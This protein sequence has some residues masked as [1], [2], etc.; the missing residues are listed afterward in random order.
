MPKHY[1]FLNEHLLQHNSCIPTKDFCPVSHISIKGWA[2]SLVVNRGLQMVVKEFYSFI[3]VSVKLLSNQ[4]L[5]QV[6]KT[7]PIANY[8]LIKQLPLLYGPYFFLLFTALSF[9]VLVHFHSTQSTA[10]C[11]FTHKT[12]E[13]QLNAIAD[14]ENI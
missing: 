2:V 7:T 13:K 6:W 9:T 8:H 4:V 12:M 1:T 10:G 11:C 3:N 14:T 5:H